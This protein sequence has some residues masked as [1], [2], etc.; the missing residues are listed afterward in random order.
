MHI[1]IQ[2]SPVWPYSFPPDHGFLA[3]E[4]HSPTSPLEASAKFGGLHEN[5]YQLRQGEPLGAGQPYS[6]VEEATQVVSVDAMRS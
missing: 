6:S 4:L 3:T 2:Y 1:P 5:S